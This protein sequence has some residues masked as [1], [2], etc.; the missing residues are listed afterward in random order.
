MTLTN[1]DDAFRPSRTKPIQV[2]LTNSNLHVWKQHD[3]EICKTEKEFSAHIMEKRGFQDMF[4]PSAPRARAFAMS[5][6]RWTPPSWITSTLAQRIFWERPSFLSLLPLSSSPPSQESEK[7]KQNSS[8]YKTFWILLL[9]RWRGHGSK[10]FWCFLYS[11]NFANGRNQ[12]WLTFGPTAFLMAGR[13]LIVAGLR[14][15]LICTMF[16]R[17][18][19]SIYSY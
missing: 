2:R 16:M 5:V 4:T 12:N 6:P 15:R 7:A 10:W 13:T 11:E 3:Y 17:L 8:A 1:L 18:R 14:Q 9:T 19:A